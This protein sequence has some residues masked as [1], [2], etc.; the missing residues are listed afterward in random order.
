MSVSLEDYEMNFRTRGDVRE[1]G[2]VF[3]KVLYGKDVWLSPASYAARL[4]DKK[5]FAKVYREKH[6]QGNRIYALSCAMRARTRSR[7]FR[8]VA[9]AK[10]KA[11]EL[12][13]CDWNQLAAHIE[14]QF[15]D[16]MGWHNR[17]EW[18]IDHIIPL[19][20][21]HDEYSFR[22]LCHYTNLRPLWKSDNLHKSSNWTP[23][24][25]CI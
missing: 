24:E 22:M 9:G 17:R 11:N 12:I 4:V 8:A 5:D 20:S 1:D 2:K 6:L 19:S 13:G 25:Y 21:A 15:V 10:Q 7:L 18:H 3:W 16:G 23:P 14:K